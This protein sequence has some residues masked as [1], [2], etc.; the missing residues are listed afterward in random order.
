M[1][2]IYKIFLMG[3]PIVLLGI[4]PIGVVMAEGMLLRTSVT[5]MLIDENDVVLEFT[6]RFEGG[7]AVQVNAGSVPGFGDRSAVRVS[8]ER[9]P[10]LDEASRRPCQQLIEK[11]Y[12]DEVPTHWIE[13][14]PASE[15][16][17]KIRLSDLYDGV[18]GNIGQCDLII[19][20]TYKI[21]TEDAV[22]F[23]RVAGTAVVSSDGTVSLPTT[24]LVLGKSW[25]YT[26]RSDNGDALDHP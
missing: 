21:Y 1:N 25:K 18:G 13:I 6:V 26:E 20:W 24:T 16:R 9:V 19:N 5:T 15:F 10:D 2:N 17:H 22:R 23:P 14:K 11:I 8:A 4:F 12:I 3:L 7:Q